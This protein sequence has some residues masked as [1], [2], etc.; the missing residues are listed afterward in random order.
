MAA[1]I[2][3]IVRNVSTTWSRSGGR[4]SAD[5]Q[6]R[7]VL[8]QLQLD[9]EGALYRDDG[10]VW[11]AAD[12]LNGATGGATGLWIAAARN[13]K[14]ATN[15]SLQMTAPDLANAR[16]GTAGVWLRF[17]TSSRS[18]TN[19]AGVV[20]TPSAPVAV[21]YQII[22]R[23]TATNTANTVSQ[24]Y[25]L[26]RAEARPATINGRI[27]V[28]EAGFNIT[29]SNYT[30]STSGTNNGSSTGDPRSIQVPGTNAGGTGRNL[31]SVIADNVIDFG[32]RCYVRDA[33]E[34]GRPAGGLRLTFPATATGALANAATTRLRAS[35]PPGVPPA[36]WGTAQPFPDVVDIMVRILTDEGAEQI[37][38]IEKVQTPA[39]TVP[40]KYN[41]N[42]QEWW[43]GIALENSRVYTRRVVLNSRSL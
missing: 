14:P 19:A 35:L 16:F 17:F 37:A 8:D 10:N 33:P 38:N 13:P 1:F 30:T 36:Q 3:V 9:L 7:I 22:R 15:L 40:Q 12:V 42:A 6:A 24:G 34:P 43:W 18:V 21:G 27:G 39:L 23:Y 2:A 20:T 29:S 26:H 41:G 28:L 32:V 31:D 4:L 25:L 5:A 11:L